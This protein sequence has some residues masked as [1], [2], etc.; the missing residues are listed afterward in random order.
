MSISAESYN[1]DEGTLVRDT[2]D[3]V[4]LVCKTQNAATAMVLWIKINPNTSETV[5]ISAGETMLISDQRFI[6][7]K[8]DVYSTY[9]LS[10]SKKNC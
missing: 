4:T 10:V 7:K 1:K 9:T 5:T 3:V 6:V 2:G 8:N